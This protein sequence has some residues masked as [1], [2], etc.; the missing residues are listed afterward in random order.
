M[1][2]CLGYGGGEGSVTLVGSV[3]SQNGNDN[4]S[5]SIFNHDLNL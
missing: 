2:V 3:D 1:C 4:R 5:L